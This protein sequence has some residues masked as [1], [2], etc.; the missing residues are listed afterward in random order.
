MLIQR[1]I[2]VFTQ[3]AAEHDVVVAAEE[4]FGVKIPD[5]LVQELK[6][7]GDAVSYIDDPEAFAP[8]MIVYASR[9]PSW[10]QLD[11]GLATFPEMAPAAD[12]PVSL[13]A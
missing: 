4:K 12:R 13:D 1:E 8:Q 7:V 5:H 6:A 3:G 10:A 11:A 9:A 2:P